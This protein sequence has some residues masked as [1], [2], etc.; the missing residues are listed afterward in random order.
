MLQA[1]LSYSQCA[2]LHIPGFSIRHRSELLLDGTEVRVGR[3]VS[4][5]AIQG[6]G[7]TS[8]N[9]LSL[10]PD[11]ERDG[12]KE[13]TNKG[14]FP[15]ILLRNSPLLWGLS[16]GHKQPVRWRVSPSLTPAVGGDGGMNPSPPVP[17]Q[18]H[19]RSARPI[20]TTQPGPESV[21]SSS[22]S[23]FYTKNQS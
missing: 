5:K 19:P 6:V 14:T 13:Q 22:C 11:M 21:Y 16:S 20:A 17:Q 2:S 4:A 1:P 12:R 15:T 18:R 7:L 10:S 3:N 8:K 23:G 9:P